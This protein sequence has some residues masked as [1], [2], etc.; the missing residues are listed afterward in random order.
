MRTH[1]IPALRGLFLVFVLPLTLLMI[2][3]RTLAQGDHG[4]TQ[5]AEAPQTEGSKSKSYSHGSPQGMKGS[6]HAKSEGSASKQGKGY[7]HGSKH[8]YGKKEGSYGRHGYSR[9]GSGKYGHGG[10]GGHGRDPF[11]HI[12]H[13][14]RPLGLSA[15][16]VQQIRDKQFEFKKQRIALRAQ[17]EIAH[18]E[19]DKLVHS[20]KVDESAIRAVGDRLK[21]IK[22]QKIDGMIEA[23]IGLLKILTDEQRKKIAALHAQ[24][25]GGGHGYKGHSR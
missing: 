11:R 20:G 8:G 13:F 5:V 3:D 1:L 24:R 15:D 2:P 17:H 12:L 22:S 23:K 14:A 7:G 9:H 19:M 25:A 21:Q 4:I 10:R 18:L 16:Q 6:P